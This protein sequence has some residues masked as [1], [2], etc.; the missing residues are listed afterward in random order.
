LHQQQAVVR[1]HRNDDHRAARVAALGIL[2]AAA[3]DQP[4]VVAFGQNAAAVGC[5]LVVAVLVHVAVFPRRWQGVD[6][7]LS[8]L[9][10]CCLAGNLCRC[11]GSQAAPGRNH[12]SV[13]LSVDTA[14]PET[15]TYWTSY[16]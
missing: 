5:P 9:P 8:R 1:R 15:R 12:L 16:E 2:P 10:L 14:D 11:A 4:Q 7:S 13:A 3:A 6:G